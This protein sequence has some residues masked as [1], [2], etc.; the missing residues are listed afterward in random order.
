LNVFD[1][2][3]G[4]LLTALLL[5]LDYAI[6]LELAEPLIQCLHHTK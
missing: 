2:N 1:L 6:D 5:L 3:V 4:G